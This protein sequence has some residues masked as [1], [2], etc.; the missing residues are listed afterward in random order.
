[1]L[2]RHLSLAVSSH[3]EKGCSSPKCCTKLSRICAKTPSQSGTCVPIVFHFCSTFVPLFTKTG[4]FV[5]LLFHFCSSFNQN[6]NFCSTFVPLL[7]QFQPKLEQNIHFCSTFVPVSTKSGILCPGLFHFCSNFVQNW[8]CVPV[9]RQHALS[10]L[11][12]CWLM[13][14]PIHPAAPSYMFKHWLVQ[15]LVEPS[16]EA[17]QSCLKMSPC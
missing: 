3:I 8:N 2:M 9:G 11:D 13:L 10:H 7:F 14:V 4:T 12:M 17:S 6:W 1:M 16:L 5:P 15:F